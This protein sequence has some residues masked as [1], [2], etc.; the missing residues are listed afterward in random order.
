MPPRIKSP[1]RPASSK[2]QLK[3]ESKD[4]QLTIEQLLERVKAPGGERRA[5]ASALVHF[6]SREPLHAG[7]LPVDFGKAFG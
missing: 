2:Q 7:I 6:A 3:S 5:A 4:D 1:E